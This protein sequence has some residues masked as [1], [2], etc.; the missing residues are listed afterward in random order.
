[1]PELTAGSM[2]DA[3]SAHL[4][5]ENPRQAA[6]LLFQKDAER[7]SGDELF[8]LFYFDLLKQL[9]YADAQAAFVV[10]KTFDWSVKE[11]KAGHPAVIQLLDQHVLM[12]CSSFD[13]ELRA[14]DLMTMKSMT[15]LEMPD[16]PL[17]SLAINLSE[18]ARRRRQHIVA[19]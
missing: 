18:L 19:L 13:D 9:S 5:T 6:W 15:H 2:F 10:S 3:L 12:Y 17:I 14:W 11:M 7:L 4:H 16:T 8:G 1:M